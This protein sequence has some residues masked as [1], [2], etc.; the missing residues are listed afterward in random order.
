MKL[1]LYL[2]ALFLSALFLS[3][4]LADSVSGSGGVVIQD[5][6]L[7]SSPKR[8]VNV[9]TNVPTPLMV[10]F[11][12]GKYNYWSTISMGA[13]LASQITNDSSIA[14]TTV[15]DALN[16][17]KIGTD[18]SHTQNTDI[19]L[20]TIKTLTADQ[21]QLVDD[22]FEVAV[23]AMYSPFG[24]TFKAGVSGSLKQI[25][26]KCCYKTRS[27]GDLEVKIQGVT[28]GLPN[29]TILSSQ[30]VSQASFTIDI[31]TNTIITLPIP[32][33]LVAGS[34]YAITVNVPI[35]M[36]EYDFSRCNSDLYADGAVVRYSAGSWSIYLPAGTVDLVFQTIV[37]VGVNGELINNGVLKEDLTVTPGKKIT[38]NG[39][40]RSN[41]P[42]INMTTNDWLY[43]GSTNVDDSWRQGIVN[44]SFAI[45]VRT[46]GS[47]TNATQFNKP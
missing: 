36:A 20:R 12:D 3:N 15:K 22:G 45:Q 1:K 5:G 38:L 26:L 27:A 34:N 46:S 43:W 14:G 23:G 6:Q 13:T 7:K 10:L 25:I 9:A 40:A 35:G 29:G 4:S 39:E 42:S 17:L 16:T 19:I 8:S 18:L 11:T 31:T 47:W 33:I 41:W 37:E 44:G 24:Q 32:I 2:S 21:Q 28:G 30:M